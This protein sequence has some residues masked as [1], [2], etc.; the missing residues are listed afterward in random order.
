[1]RL[2][3][4][5]LFLGLTACSSQYN[6]PIAND[7]RFAPVYPDPKPQK[8]VPTGSIF[9]KA[10]ANELYSDLK[11][12]KLGDIITIVLTEQTQAKKRA[13]NDISTENDVGIG[14]LTVGGTPITIAGRSTEIGY[15][16]NYDTSRQA[17]ADQSNS[18]SGS[19]TASVVQVL[20]NGNLVVRGEKWITINNGEEFI[21]LSGL[22]R[23]QDIETDNTIVS[24]RVADARI[25]YSG[26][27]AF[28][29]SQ[30]PGWL[31]RFFLSWWPI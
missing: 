21:R 20:S 2:L 23:P 26:T 31:S 12:H 29:D 6:T 15:G 27:G 17:G 7:P 4:S 18:L 19:I 1:M 25:Q 16:D 10:H 28:A 5:I 14:A 3:L 13:N 8:M 11:A 22:I 9:Q 24:T 30:Q